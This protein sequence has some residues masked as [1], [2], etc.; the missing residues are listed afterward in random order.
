MERVIQVED[1]AGK[2]LYYAT[3]WVSK[4]CE[5]G[6]E[7]I[8]D[9]RKI[10]K[11]QIYCRVD[12][13]KFC[14][15]VKGEVE[16]SIKLGILKNP[17]NI[18][19]E[20]KE[21][22]EKFFEFL[23]GKKLGF[24]GTSMCTE[25]VI[26]LNAV[27]RVA[28][29]RGF[30]YETIEED[31]Q[32]VVDKLCLDNKEAFYRELTQY[33]FDFWDEFIVEL[34]GEDIVE[35]HRPHPHETHEE[36]EDEGVD[37]CEDVLKK[38]SGSLLAALKSVDDDADTDAIKTPKQV[39]VVVYERIYELTDGT[40]E[41]C[42]DTEFAEEVCSTFIATM[43]LEQYIHVMREFIMEY[44]NEGPNIYCADFMGGFNQ[45]FYPETF[46]SDETLGFMF[47]FLL[48]KASKGLLHG[49]CSKTEYPNCICRETK[50]KT[51]LKYGI[52]REQ[53]HA[54]NNERLLSYIVIQ[55]ANMY[56]ES[57]L[58]ALHVPCSETKD[59]D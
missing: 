28:L 7:I 44:K 18:G 25:P 29:V 22:L 38:L 24:K 50:V 51:L 32:G 5:R 23:A 12:A 16:A 20:I 30:L 42:V 48:D 9:Y 47:G 33:T 10:N 31:Y 17:V 3:V 59:N 2:N 39:F 54:T 57:V 46:S 8:S 53:V 52:S 11:I 56:W 35:E 40:L 15:I 58:R 6:F 49:L 26:T 36:D 43:N 27:D 37:A 21:V 34:L 4:P 19:G 1:Y 55:Y 14:E 41:R 13:E 45:P